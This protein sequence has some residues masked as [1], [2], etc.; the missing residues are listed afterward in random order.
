MSNHMQIK[1]SFVSIET[2]V[3]TR[4]TSVVILH[5]QRVI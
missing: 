3:E 2:V 5:L 4:Q 1:N